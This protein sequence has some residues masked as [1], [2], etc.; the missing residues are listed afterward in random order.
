MLRRLA[1]AGLPHAPTVDRRYRQMDRKCPCILPCPG[2]AEA[3]GRTRAQA[4]ETSRIGKAGSAER[5]RKCAHRQW[6]PL[7]EAW[8]DVD[9]AEY[10]AAMRN[11]DS[12]HEP[13]PSQC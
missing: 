8:L 7:L 2:A 4:L 10:P 11:R 1:R 12:A 5:S 9:A 6:T 13:D 3:H